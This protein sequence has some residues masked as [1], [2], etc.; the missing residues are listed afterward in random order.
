MRRV[1]R[2]TGDH[3]VRPSCLTLLPPPGGRESDQIRPRARIWLALLPALVFVAG[4]GYSIRA[5]YDRSIRTVYVP[6]FKST[7]YRR[8]LNL[9]LTEL[10]QKEIERRSGYKVVGRPDEADT[11]LEGTILYADKNVMVE[12]PNNLPRELMSLM[13]VEV[14][15]IDNRTKDPKARAMPP[16]RVLE[17][18]PFFPEVGETTNIAFERTMARVARDIVNMMETPW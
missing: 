6:I 5:P 7:T 14:R 3:R 17:N 16:T 13:T 4:C 9:Q 2:H 10:V 1:T 15:W 18:V 11:I 12:N 8:D